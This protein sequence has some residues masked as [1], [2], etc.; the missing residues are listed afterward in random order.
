MD[1]IEKVKKIPLNNK[2]W[3]YLKTIFGNISNIYFMGNVWGPYNRRFGI[4]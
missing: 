4:F 2:R 3:F 1:T